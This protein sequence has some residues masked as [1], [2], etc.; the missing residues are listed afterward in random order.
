MKV[1]ASQ[2]GEHGVLV[3]FLGPARAAWVEGK[4]ATRAE[5]PSV[6]DARRRAR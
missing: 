5:I 1:A 4:N 3:R 2:S 6:L